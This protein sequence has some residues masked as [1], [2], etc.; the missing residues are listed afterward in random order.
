MTNPAAA[1][2]VRPYPTCTARSRMLGERVELRTPSMGPAPG[3]LFSLRPAFTDEA[4]HRPE[5]GV[6]D[7]AGEHDLHHLSVPGDLNATCMSG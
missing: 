7:A 3:V 4:R 5:L 6:I 2:T 1:L